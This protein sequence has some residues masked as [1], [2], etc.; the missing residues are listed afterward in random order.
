MGYFP[1][2]FLKIQAFQKKHLFGLKKKNKQ[3]QF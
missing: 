2:Y 1:K 3:P